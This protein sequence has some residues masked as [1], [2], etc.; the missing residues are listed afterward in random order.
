MESL[1]LFALGFLIATLFAIVASQFIWRRAVTVTTRNLAGSDP[2]GTD[3]DELH[4]ELA[5]RN[6]RL[7][8]LS[9]RLEKLEADR[10]SVDRERERAEATDKA[11]E[12]E[13]LRARL[14]ELENRLAHS[15]AERHTLEEQL[16]AVNRRF[17]DFEEGL[18]KDE[19]RVA[20]THAG[21]RTIGEKAARLAYD[22]NNIIEEIAPRRNDAGAAK[23]QATERT[24]SRTDPVDNAAD[25]AE[26][27]T[28][29]PG[30]DGVA[31]SLEEL[32]GRVQTAY[33]APE[34]VATGTGEA[35]KD[36]AG[37]PEIPEEPARKRAPSPLDER[38]RAL[39]AGLP[40]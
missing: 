14:T 6:S 26:G 19:L 10:S 31:D 1:M 9:A 12:M 18:Q 4:E 30:D 21:L 24:A 17:A 23:A 11:D 37:E 8:E 7:A 28:D 32:T 34:T 2:A 15:E 36:D 3:R 35:E 40:H 33:S 16:E 38:I 13:G 22:L 29:S 5:D 27:K 39:E 25:D 20:E